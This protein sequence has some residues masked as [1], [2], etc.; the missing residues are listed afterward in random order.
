MQSAYGR[1]WNEAA[2]AALL[3]DE[4][5]IDLAEWS[6]AEGLDRLTGHDTALTLRLWERLE[7]I[8]YCEVLRTSFA[9]RLRGVVRAAGRALD[10]LLKT[11]VEGEPLAPV[12]FVVGLRSRATDPACCTLRLHAELAPSGQLRVT[13]GMPADYCAHPMELSR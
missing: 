6:Q 10:R 12:D 11:A 13:L 1:R 2:R 9:E 5:L 4:T 7:A 3:D 8:P